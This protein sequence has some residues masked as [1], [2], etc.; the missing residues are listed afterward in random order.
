MNRKFTSPLGTAPPDLFGTPPAP[1]WS[2]RSVELDRG[3]ELMEELNPG[4]TERRA[5]HL[6]SS[7]KGTPEL[8]SRKRNWTCG[9]SVGSIHSEYYGN[10][11]CVLYFISEGFWVPLNSMGTDVA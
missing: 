4:S 8:W 7:Q 5:V 9:G 1:L 10:S 11:Q 3:K 6:K 2:L